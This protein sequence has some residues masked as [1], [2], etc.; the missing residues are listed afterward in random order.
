MAE[1]IPDEIVC[2]LL[3][4]TSLTLTE[5]GKLGILQVMKIYNEV[6]LQEN[7]ERWES[8]YNLAYLVSHIH[9]AM[10]RGRNS[11]IWKVEDFYNI[12]RP[13]HKKEIVKDNLAEKL[14]IKMPED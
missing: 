5:I 14:G 6:M 4:K 3:R 8:Q 10:P 11:K 12:P 13:S 2:F 9:N 7:Q 1:T